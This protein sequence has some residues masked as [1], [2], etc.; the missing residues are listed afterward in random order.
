[1]ATSAADEA[2]TSCA[3]E[4]RKMSRLMKKMN[5]VQVIAVRVPVTT[6]GCQRSTLRRSYNIHLFTDC[7]ASKTT[8]HKNDN[9]QNVSNCQNCHND[10]HTT[11]VDITNYLWQHRS[12]RLLHAPLLSRPSEAAWDDGVSASCTVSLIVR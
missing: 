1:M 2:A 12:N 3:A 9:R 11:F 10:G 4:E 6:V 7:T 5:R 8:N